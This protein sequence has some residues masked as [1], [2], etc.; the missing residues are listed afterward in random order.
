MLLEK[1][2][3][4]IREIMEIT[5]KMEEALQGED[6][7]RFSSELDHRRGLFARITELQE[8][9]TPILD[10][11]MDA[12]LRIPDE[13]VVLITRNKTALQT[14]LDFDEQ[15]RQKGEQLRQSIAQRLGET[16]SR[17]KIAAGYGAPGGNGKTGLLQGKS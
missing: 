16:R 14:I 17:R 6:V 5:R 11:W 9:V 3:A 2:N 8:S 4:V 15:C 10:G 1:Q 12:G 13:V 7:E